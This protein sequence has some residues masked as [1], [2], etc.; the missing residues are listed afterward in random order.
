MTLFKIL[1]LVTEINNRSVVQEHPGNVSVAIE[2]CTH[3]SS[4]PILSKVR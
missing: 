1:Y 2:T 3:Q 4:Q